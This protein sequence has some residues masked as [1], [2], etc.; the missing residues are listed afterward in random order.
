MPRVMLTGRVIDTQ[1]AALRSYAAEVGLP[2]YQATVRALELGI[3]VLVG[4]RGP[5]P[6]KLEEEGTPY[7]VHDD[8]IELKEAI[9]KLTTRAELTDGLVQRT[10]YMAGA[11]YSASLASQPQEAYRLKSI[12][13]DADQ[14]FIEQLAKARA[15]VVGVTFHQKPTSQTRSA[16]TTRDPRLDDKDFDRTAGGAL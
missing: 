2:M 14:V 15:N 13:R 10:L 4:W 6:A 16:A 12:A 9:D 7:P 5:E 8:L 3:A 11:A 1:A